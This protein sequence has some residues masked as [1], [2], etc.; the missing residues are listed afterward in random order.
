[1]P[2]KKTNLSLMLEEARLE[3]N[4]TKLPRAAILGPHSIISPTNSSLLSPMQGMSPSA[5]SSINQRD[6][7]VNSSDREAQRRSKMKMVQKLA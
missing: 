2:I 1:M 6:S 3:I 7:G 4:H 5:N